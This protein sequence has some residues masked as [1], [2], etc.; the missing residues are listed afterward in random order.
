MVC[1]PPLAL[2]PPTYL[3]GVP[4]ESGCC[5][6]CPA[7]LGR[8]TEVGDP[9]ASLSL[10]SWVKHSSG[11]ER[12][13]FVSGKCFWCCPSATLKRVWLVPF[14]FSTP[15]KL[16]ISKR[17]VLSLLVSRLNNGLS[18]H[19]FPDV[20]CSSTLLISVASAELF[21]WSQWLPCSEE[22][23][24][25]TCRQLQSGSMVLMQG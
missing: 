10:S 9:M 15:R 17:F 19:L 21:P 4:A 18:L 7:E 8:S 14:C 5:R 23:K 11:E 3:K 25:E 1:G 6:P 22:H 20:L 16:K 24:L 2:L 12:A 13:P